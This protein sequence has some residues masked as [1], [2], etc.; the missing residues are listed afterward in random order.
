[1][2]PMQQLEHIINEVKG[3]TC[4]MVRYARN[5]TSNEEDK[6]YLVSKE[7]RTKKLRARLK[8]KKKKPWI[9]A[10]RAP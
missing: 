5:G 9:E 4:A 3:K 7:E 1:M 10:R 6:L 8:M 2:Q